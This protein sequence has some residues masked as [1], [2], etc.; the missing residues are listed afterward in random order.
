MRTTTTHALLR[1]FLGD[2]FSPTCPSSKNGGRQIFKTQFHIQYTPIIS[3]ST[4]RVLIM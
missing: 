2:I 4:N 3:F 1:R